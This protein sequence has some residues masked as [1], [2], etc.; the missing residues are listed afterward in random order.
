M[1]PVSEMALH[2]ARIIFC[3]ERPRP[4]LPVTQSDGIRATAGQGRGCQRKA[5]SLLLVRCTEKFPVVSSDKH[6]TREV[7]L[8]QGN[9]AITA[10]RVRRCLAK[11]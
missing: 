9:K 10:V 7:A 11:S 8:T 3:R 4:R 1:L 5:P 2:L 6:C